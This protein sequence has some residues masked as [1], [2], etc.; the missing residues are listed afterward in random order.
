MFVTLKLF[1]T[2][3][4]FSQP[5]TPGLWQGEV[6]EGCT[7]RDLITLL[8]SMEA[9]IAAVAVNGEV[10]PLDSLVPDGAMLMMVTHVNGGMR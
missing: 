6:P 1:G 9:E 8:G 7:I 4:R 3:R 5:G 10:R 2:L